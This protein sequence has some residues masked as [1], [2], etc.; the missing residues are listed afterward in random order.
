[1]E[2]LVLIKTGLWMAIIAAGL[3]A[4]ALVIWQLRK[5]GGSLSDAMNRALDSVFGPSTVTT[6][7]AVQ[8]FINQPS[9]NGYVPWK[10]EIVEDEADEEFPPK[11]LVK[12]LT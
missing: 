9:N 10:P 2:N 4:L 5:A 6:P 7:Q 11:W 1:M 12:G 3:L 8:D